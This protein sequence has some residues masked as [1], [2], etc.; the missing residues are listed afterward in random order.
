[1]D[2]LV[3]DVK[4]R[5]EAVAMNSEKKNKFVAINY[6]TCDKEYVERFEHLFTTRARAI[7]RIPGFISMEVLKPNSSNDNYLIVSHWENGDAFKNWTKSPEFLEG[8]KR[9]FEDMKKYKDE[10]KK[11]P[12]S[13]DFKTYEIL[14]D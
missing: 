4:F 12:M 10:G 1:M 7:D 2:N 8:H 5:A 3:E 13:S 14:T 11:P 6:I 9:G